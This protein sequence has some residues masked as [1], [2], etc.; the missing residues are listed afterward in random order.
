MQPRLCRLPTALVGAALL[1]LLAGC[2]SSPAG[3]GP[4]SVDRA[5]RLERRGDHIEAA[6]MYERLAAG[7]AA[8]DRV[9]F[10][11]AAARAWLAANRADDAQRALDLAAAERTPAQRFEGELLAA[12]IALARGQY[13]AAWRQI[14]QVPE[15]ARPADASRL[16]QLR[17]QVALRAGQPIE[18]VRAG[19]ARERVAANDAERARTRRDL[20]SDL[21]GAID[22]GLRVD[23]ATSNEPLIRGWLEIAQ[24]AAAAGRSPLAAQSSIERWRTRFPGHPA[25]TI[26]N[27]EILT[28]AER[29][30]VSGSAAALASVSGPVALLLPLTG[31]QSAPA[32]LIRDGFQAAV[33]RMPAAERPVLRVYDTGTLPVSTALRNAQDEGAAFIVG[34]LT[35]EEVRTAVDQHPAV[36]LLLLNTLDAGQAGSQVYQ[37]ALSP[38][39]E[40]RQIARQITG[41]GHRNAVVLAPSGEWGSRVAAAFAEELTRS[42]GAV[43]AQGNYDLARNDLTATMTAVLGIEESRARARRLQQ[44]TGTA[45]QF[46]PHPRPDIDAIFVAGYQPLAVRQINPQLRFFNAGDVPTYI[47]QDA[48][49]ADNNANRDLEGMRLLET[50][51]TL[52]SVGAVADL[53]AATQAE[54]AAQ[55][56]RQSRYFAFGYDAAMLAMELRR[57]P[58]AAWPLAGLTGRL[59]IS[60]EGRIERSLNWARL[61][62][63]NIEAFDPVR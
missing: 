45:L 40:A 49:D 22:N 53:R 26:A 1:A 38:E 30:G 48:L 52:D 2:A 16:L 31:R 46:D 37:Y 51:W 56:Q 32:M 61:R 18:A 28:P 50:P 5:E 15:P 62:E 33:A 43:I 42:G 41:A 4:A 24:I 21:R 6:Q 23:P 8:P 3:P 13:A 14:S 29:P 19:I 7:N 39:D 58:A 10:A 9:D 44:V 35:R 36:P 25:A 34:P 11:F 12:E 57:G 47:T 20:L 63:G 17:Q 60:A 27:A 55:G 59:Q 54:W